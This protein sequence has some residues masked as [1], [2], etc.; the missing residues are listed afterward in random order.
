MPSLAKHQSNDFVKLLLEGD[1]KSGKTGALASLVCAGYKLRILDYDNGLD[2]L[3]QY[4]LRDCPGRLE[5]VEFRT[6]RDKRKSSPLGPII[7]GAPRAFADGVRLLDRWRYEADGDTIDYGVPAD[8][9]PEC[10][11]VLDSLTFFSD[12]AWD[13]REPLTPKSNQSGKYDVRAVYKDAQDA[14]ESVLALL[15]SEGF[16]TNVVVISHIKYVD[17]PDGTRK[18]YPSSV[19]SAL[20]PLILRYFNNVVKF[21]NRA[22]KRK[23][24][25][26]ATPMYDLATAKPFVMKESYDIDSGMAEIFE[27]LTGRKNE[28]CLISKKSSTNP[29]VKSNAPSR[30]PQAPIRRL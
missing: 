1:S 28:S 9:G 4:V 17:N 6:L 15:T 3:K 21:S 10:I 18:G 23:I 13:F 19:G 29:P 24:E 30:S 5:N 11:L 7:D 2:V 22:G 26:V 14:V 27:V 8:W 12:A 20:S 16:R 25:T